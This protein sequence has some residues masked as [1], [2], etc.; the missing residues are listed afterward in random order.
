LE[1]RV[2]ILEKGLEYMKK[3]IQT[4]PGFQSSSVEAH[5]VQVSPPP[6]IDVDS[7]MASTSSETSGASLLQKVRLIEKQKS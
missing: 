6:L 5:Q 7:V 1:E 3:M 4:L 2:I